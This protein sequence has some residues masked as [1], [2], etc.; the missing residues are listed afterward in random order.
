MAF[1]QA[2]SGPAAI[3]VDEYDTLTDQDL[4]DQIE[5][6]WVPRIPPNL[7]VRNRIPMQTS[8][9]GQVSDGPI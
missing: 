4:L 5:R 2:H 6:S 8:R 1:S 3:L 9:R 7:D